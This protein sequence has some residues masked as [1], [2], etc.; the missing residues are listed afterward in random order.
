M[1]DYE[2]AIERNVQEHGWHCTSVIDPDGVAPDFA[3][4]VGFMETLGMPE[5]IVF[6]L[7]S[8]LMH[9]M[10]WSAF[11]DLQAG[12]TINDGDRWAGL[13]DGFDCVAR[14]VHPTNLTREYFN[15]AL[16]YHGDPSVHGPLSAFQIV[17]PGAQQGHFP[18]DAECDPFV[19]EMQPP[20][21]VPGAAIQ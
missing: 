3:Y 1:T 18:W 10:L 9:N 6:G 11:R 19:R 7:D 21:Y 4:S 8:K 17:W 5:L 13:L 12:K 2:L 16:W 15:S 20:L 14:A